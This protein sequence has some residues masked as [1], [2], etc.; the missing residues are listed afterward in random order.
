[1][2]PTEKLTPGGTEITVGGRPARTSPRAPSS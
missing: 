2:T 1:M